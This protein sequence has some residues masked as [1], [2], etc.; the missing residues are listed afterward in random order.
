MIILLA[1]DKIEI[2]KDMLFKYQ[3]KINDLYNIPTGNVKKLVC[4][5]FS[6]RNVCAS[7]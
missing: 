1:P 4:N 5:F 6:Q 7:L 2:K 3:L